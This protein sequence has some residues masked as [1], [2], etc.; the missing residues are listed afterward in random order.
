MNN[1]ETKDLETEV[2]IVSSVQLKWLIHEQLMQ[3]VWPHDKIDF[4]VLTSLA[5]PESNCTF[6]AKLLK[7]D[8]AGKINFCRGSEAT[9]LHIKSTEF[10]T[11]ELVLL[12]NGTILESKTVNLKPQNSKSWTGQCMQC[13]SKDGCTDKEIGTSTQCVDGTVACISGTGI[14]GQR[15]NHCGPLDELPVDLKMNDCVQMVSQQIRY[16]RLFTGPLLF[17][18]CI[19]CDL[20]LAEKVIIVC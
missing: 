4:L 11:Q 10:G 7:D 8:Q 6:N 16:L 15:K 14:R 3:I 12:A 1:H 2:Q 13:Q 9:I 18:C 17:V 20:S 5:N 19:T